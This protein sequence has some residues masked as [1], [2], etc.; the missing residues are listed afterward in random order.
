ME[1]FPEELELI[2]LF[3]VDSKTED[4]DLPFYYRETTFDFVMNDLDYHIVVMPSTNQFIISVKDSTKGFTL[5]KAN[6]ESVS[7]VEILK[8]SKDEA[9]F[10]ITLD[11]DSDR[12]FTLVEIKLKPYFSVEIKECFH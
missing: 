5:F 3:C 10:R 9:C 2:S 8:D 1:N 11:H 6:Y 7:N 4:L 12:F